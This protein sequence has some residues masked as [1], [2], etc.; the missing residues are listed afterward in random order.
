[1]WNIFGNVRNFL[2]IN[3]KDTFLPQKLQ[4]DNPE[5]FETIRRGMFGSSIDS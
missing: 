1:M 2:T 5:V 3:N 4:R